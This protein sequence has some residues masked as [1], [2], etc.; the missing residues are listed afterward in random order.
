MLLSYLA[1][2]S[3]CLK[4][5]RDRQAQIDALPSEYHAPITPFDVNILDKP[6]SDIV[7][8]V[9]TGKL[10]PQHVLTAYG[11]KALKAQAELNCLTEVLLSDAQVWAEECNRKGPLAGMP[12]SLKDMVNVRGYDSCLGYAAWVGKPAERDSAIVRLLRDAGAVPFVK[13]QIPIT[14]LSYESA[15]D[16]LGVAENPHK[17]G[18]SPGGSTGGE[19]ALLAYGGSRI[20]I[21]SDVAGSVRVPSHYSGVYTIKSSTTRFIRRDTST[22]NAGQEGVLAVFSPMART[23]DD[24]EYFWKAIMSMN[25]WKYDHTVI[26]LPWREVRLPEK[27][28]KFGVMW[29][30][31][32]VTPS[33]ACHRALRDVV[34]SLRDNGYQVVPINPPSPYEG[35]K[36]ASALIADACE[37]AC[38]K[39]MPWENND[40]GMKQAMALYRLPRWLK[41]IYAWYLRYIRRDDVY[42]GLVEGWH[43]KSAQEIFALVAKREEYRARWFDF[44]NETGI[45]FVLTCPNAM[46][47]VPHR[48]MRDAFTNCLYSFLFNLL[49]YPAG[50]MPVTRVDR[51]LDSLDPKFRPRNVIEAGAYKL[52]DAEKMHGLPV[53]VQMVGRRL[54][55]EKVMEG[56]KLIQRLLVHDGKEY[57]LLHT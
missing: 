14:L 9:Q 48:G 13:T 36:I 30:D 24:L 4:K 10:S 52:Y 2:R 40:P 17:K 15:S 33:P 37:V 47:A 44:W 41:R 26:E 20:G 46:P 19:A 51:E 3:A 34:S 43:S 38:R 23:L 28:V 11:K 55:E 53:G 31:G 25:P 49:D 50:V 27:K 32:V 12:V 39:V 29:T 7:A 6:V 57:E 42:A 45:D 8:Q 54:Q 1:Y 21:G 56:M 5:Q 18:Y 22:S 35:F 16:A